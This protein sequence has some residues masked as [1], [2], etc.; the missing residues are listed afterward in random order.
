ME[1]CGRSGTD[2]CTVQYAQRHA[3]RP[4]FLPSSLA[5]ARNTQCA[6]LRQMEHQRGWLWTRLSPIP[7][8]FTYLGQKRLKIFK[9]SPKTPLV[10][11][12]DKSIPGSISLVDRKVLEIQCGHDVLSLENVQLEGKKRLDIE[13]FL[14]GSGLDDT[15]V[16]G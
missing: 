4:A 11:D 9:A 10:R 3:I 8:A 16:L 2:R 12:A 1:R 6:M 13:Q 15:L 5:L 7:G 14:R